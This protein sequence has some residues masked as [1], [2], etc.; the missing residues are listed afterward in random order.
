M[1]VLI[2]PISSFRSIA[3]A[4]MRR[5]L[6]M[7]MLT[8]FLAAVAWT[9]ITFFG[10]STKLVRNKETN[11]TMSMEIPRLPIKSWY[12][13]SMTPMTYFISFGY[14]FYYVLFSMVQ[15]NLSDVLFCSWVLFAC[16]QLQHLK[17][18]KKQ[19]KLGNEIVAN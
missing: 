19:W 15:S 4:K 18:I 16:E 12:P 13:W 10:D 14:Q 7:V 2:W 8:T 5:L 9:T 6:L 11:E 17:V 3:L 1:F